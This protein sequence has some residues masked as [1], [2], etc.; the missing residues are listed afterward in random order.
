M[1]SPAG[2]RT[3]GPTTTARGSERAHALSQRF[4]GVRAATLALAAPLSAEDCVVQSMPD[5][6]PVKWHLAHTTWFFETFVLAAGDP[7]SEPFHAQYSFLYNSYYEAVGRRVERPRRGLQTRPSLTEVQAYRRHVDERVEV[8]LGSPA[9]A[10]RDELLDVLELGLNHEQ[11][12]QELLLTDVKHLL[13]HNALD[14]V[15][16]VRPALQRGRAGALSFLPFA[17]GVV[18]QGHGGSGFA[19]DNEGPRHEVLLQPFAL[20]SRP[21][22]CGEFLEFI[23]ADGYRRPELWLSDGWAWAQAEAID[24]PLYWRRDGQA[25]SQFTLAGRRALEPEEPLCHVSLYEADAYARFRDARLPREAEW[26]HAARELPVEGNFVESGALHPRPTRPGSGTGP[27]AMFGDVWEWTQSPYAPYPG[28][29]AAAG[30]L[31]EYNG[32]FMVNQIVLRGGSC[33]SAQDHLRAS[34][35]NFFHPGARWQFSGLRLA[36]DA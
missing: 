29:R 28:Y 13:S 1:K 12:H 14:P 36:C 5:A 16:A 22:T 2:T 15:Y 26:E 8:W 33:A 11:Q 17:G 19:Y 9:A 4:R 35:R 24:A 30:A 7:D 25:W 3:E 34:Y 32:K 31:G 6:S 20:A 27:A 18:P 10:A 23:E 21:V